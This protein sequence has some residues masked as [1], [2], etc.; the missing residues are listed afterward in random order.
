M[1]LYL[2]I[3][4]GGTKTESAVSNGAELLGQAMAPTAKIA[5]VGEEQARQNLHQSIV[6]ACEAAKISPQA[7]DRVC[8]GISGA[9]I[10]GMR[11]WTERVIHELVPG[12]VMVS[13]D[14]SIAHRA[15]FGTMPGVLVLAGTGSFAYG[16]N[17]KGEVARAG[18]WGPGISDEGSAYWIGREALAVA[19]RL[20]DRV[21]NN[22]LLSS[23]SA[24]W[25]TSSLED[26]IRIANTDSAAKFTELAETVASMAEKGDTT[27]QTIT[28]R[29]GEELA[30]LAGVVITRLWPSD[31]VV[32]V[33]MAG[34]VLQGSTLVRRAFQ[35][36]LQADYPKAA[37]SF[38][39]VRPVLG[40]LAIA[41][42][43]GAL[44]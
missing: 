40:A 1:S 13:G 31:T 33:A 12:E 8:I 38:A 6:R 39:Y 23:I 15:A 19:L 18:G 20:H 30:A 44:K 22:G 2:G 42:Q 25:G 28:S 36:A 10:A 37:V 41:A 32:R 27:A 21:A 29:A 26:L 4:A 43:P 17:E 5:R 35:Q 16:R 11:A 34:G 3:D 9:S 7:I 14:Q 24:L